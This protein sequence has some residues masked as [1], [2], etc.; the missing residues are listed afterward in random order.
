MGRIVEKA[1][2][3]ELYNNPLHPYTRALMSAIPKVESA[4]TKPVLGEKHSTYSGEV[5]SII[6]P[7][8]GCRF[9]PRCSLAEDIC[10][11]RQPALKEK[12]GH[13]DHLVACWKCKKDNI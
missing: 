6:K 11:T 3:F 10:R 7:P 8:A 12:G 1:D 5:P 9:H 4:R 13:K 2:S